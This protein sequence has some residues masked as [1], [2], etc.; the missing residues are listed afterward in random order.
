MSTLPR[1]E[2]SSNLRH[3]L[4]H[5]ENFL[6][7][8]Q[9]P[10]CDQIQSDEERASCSAMLEKLALYH[11]AILVRKSRPLYI[12]LISIRVIRI[13]IF[14]VFLSNRNVASMV[15]RLGTNILCPGLK[16]TTETQSKFV[17][18]S[19]TSILPKLQDQY[20]N[21]SAR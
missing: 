4:H 11:A 6:T 21:S 10:H 16:A 9:P 13:H 19:C 15:Q 5:A 8:R 18:I 2:F 12:S 14:Y 7:L 20:V 17:S 1:L 3:L